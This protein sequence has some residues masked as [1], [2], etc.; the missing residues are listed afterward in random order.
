MTTI[1][2]AMR[3]TL[4]CWVTVS[5]APIEVVHNAIESEL[6]RRDAIKNFVKCLAAGGAS[7]PDKICQAR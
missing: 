2:I 5:L 1:L 7:K 4:I 6:E 3:A